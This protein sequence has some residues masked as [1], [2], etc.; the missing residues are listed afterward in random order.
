M[1]RVIIRD[2]D[3]HH[4]TRVDWLQC[5]YEPLLKKGL[6]LNFAVI[7]ELTT[8][9]VISSPS[10]YYARRGEKY[11]PFAPSELRGEAKKYKIRAEDPVAQFII[12]QDNIEVVQHGYNHSCSTSV[13]EFESNDDDEIRFRIKKGREILSDC[14]CR[15]PRFFIPPWDVVSKAAMSILKE[16]FSGISLSRCSR[17]HLPMGMLPK[18][19][20]NKV[21]RHRKL[22][23]GHFL[24][25]EHAGPLLA[26][27][28]LNRNTLSV[29]EKLLQSSDLIIL[30]NHY[31]EYYYK[32][33]DEIRLQ[34]WHAIC[35][36]LLNR[37]DVEFCAF[38]DLLA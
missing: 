21:R 14:F 17:H 10:S 22:K 20:Y 37:G 16:N 31:W 25:L 23:W 11:E 38:S 18:Y 8:D 4:F 35:E 13:K 36:Y 33:R 19:F 32:E 30:V 6:P 27:E 5:L 15:E 1:K 9:V 34:L 24:I 28:N 26:R 12:K 2:D 7:P 3:I 29:I